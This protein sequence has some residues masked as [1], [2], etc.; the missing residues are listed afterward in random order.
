MKRG[1]ALVLVCILLLTSSACSGIKLTD[2][3]ELEK[4]KNTVI[5]QDG[6]GHVP[7]FNVFMEEEEDKEQEP[8][9]EE[10]K[11]PEQLPEQLPVITPVIPTVVP[12]VI[13]EPEPEVI[14]PEP[15]P[16]QP[17]DL[18]VP[19]RGS[20]IGNVYT[21][22]YIGLKLTLPDTWLYYND[23]QIA[24]LTD[25]SMKDYNLEN[26]LS[27]SS[28]VAEMYEAMA[29]DVNSQV[30]VIQYIN[31]AK[32]GIQTYT[33]AEYIN[34]LRN[35]LTSNKDFAGKFMESK[36]YLL[37]GQEFQSL[38]FSQTVEEKEYFQYYLLKKKGDHMVLISINV[39]NRAEFQ[40]LLRCFV[41]I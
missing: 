24:T 30:V 36:P 15:E 41:A 18:S 38:Q 20:R 34:A 10:E 3:E 13:P 25:Y 4:G 35:G 6:A 2:P 11:Q 8:Q 39:A 32:G 19:G 31:L 21:N 5:A 27:S 22:R 7:E 26:Y 23:S 37:G 14:L 29:G 28:P 17:I 33:E 16:E 1:L 12:E 40:T 9:K